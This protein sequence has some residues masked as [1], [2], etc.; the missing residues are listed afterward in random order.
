MGAY[1]LHQP[2]Q[3]T[4]NNNKNLHRKREALHPPP[5]KKKKKNSEKLT[6][7]SRSRRRE[8]KATKTKETRNENTHTP[9]N[10]GYLSGDRRE[11]NKFRRKCKTS[12]ERK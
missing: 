12:S 6:E 11:R 7:S 2:D 3:H 9:P 10:T 1:L 5:R 8:D 4:Q